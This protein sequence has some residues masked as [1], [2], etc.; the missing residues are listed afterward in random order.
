MPARHLPAML[1]NA[2]FRIPELGSGR[3]ALACPLASR[4]G[5][6]AQAR[7]AGDLVVL[8]ECIIRILPWHLGHAVFNRVPFGEF[9]RAGKRINLPPKADRHHALPSVHLCWAH[10]ST[11]P[12][13]LLN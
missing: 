13:T 6:R 9:N 1:R 3:V 5:R 2:S 7:R 8:Y 10:V 4:S 12:F 11:W